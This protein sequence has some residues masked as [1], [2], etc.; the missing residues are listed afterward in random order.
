MKMLRL[1]ANYISLKANLLH[2]LQSHLPSHP[3]FLKGELTP[4]DCH[5]RNHRALPSKLLWK[6]QLQGRRHNPGRD[7]PV[8]GAAVGKWRIYLLPAAVRAVC[9]RVIKRNFP[10]VLPGVFQHGH[11]HPLLLLGT[12][13]L[14]VKPE[15]RIASKEAGSGT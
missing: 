5:I 1:G 4:G 9:A 12:G 13:A 10:L 14:A 7:Q 2:V 11:N 6:R 3:P 15:T 8:V